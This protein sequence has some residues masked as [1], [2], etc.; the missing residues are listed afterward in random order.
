MRTNFVFIVFIMVV[1]MS[2]F[3]QSDLVQ[4]YDGTLA[5]TT[6]FG[7]SGTIATAFQCWTSNSTYQLGN[8]T[9]RIRDAQ[10]GA[11]SGTISLYLYNGDGTSA[12]TKIITS[13]TTLAGSS[14]P[15]SDTNYNFDFSSSNQTITNG[16]DY[17]FVI[18]TTVLNSGAYFNVDDGSGGVGESGY[19][20]WGATSWTSTYSGTKPYVY[21]YDIDLPSPPIVLQNTS[22]EST[23]VVKQTGSLD[24]S[25]AVFQTVISSNFNV[26][27]NN[28]QIYGAYNFQIEP[29]ATNTI[30]CELL[31]DGSVKG[32]ITRSN[33]AAETGSV[34][35][36][37]NFFVLQAGNHSQELQCKKTLGG[38]KFT[39]SN[40]VGIGHFM[41]DEN[42]NTI[43]NSEKNITSQT[44]TSGSSFTQIGEINLTINNRTHVNYSQQLVVDWTLAYSN[45]HASKEI[46]SSYISIN[47]TNCSFYPRTV[48]SGTVGSV[49]GNCLLKNVTASST[50]NIKLFAN[51]TNAEYNGVMIAKNFFL[52]PN[53][54]NSTTINNINFSGAETSLLN[55]TGGNTVHF[56]TNAFIK[57]GIPVKANQSTTAQFRFSI[58]DGS[59]FNSINVSRDLTTDIGILIFHDIFEDLS[60]DNYTLELFGDCGLASCEIVG[61]EIVGYVTDTTTTTARNSFNL[62]VQ[63]NYNDGSIGGSFMALTSD[64]NTFNSVN[65]W[66]LIF[67]EKA[68]ENVS[69]SAYNNDYFNYTVFNHNTTTDLTVKLNQTII[70]WDCFEKVTNNNMNCTSPA[71]ST[72]FNYNVGGNP[73]TQS[74]NVT[75]Y[76]ERFISFNV[77]ALQNDTFNATSIYSTNLTLTSNS[78]IGSVTSCNYTIT[79]ITY[80]SFTESVIG[81]PNTYTGLINGTYNISSDCVGYAILSQSILIENV[82]Q[83]LN[84][85]LLTTNSVQLYF[86]DA[87]TLLIMNETNIT[88][89]FI[90]TTA[91]TNITSNGS[92]YVDLLS[93]DAYTII[94]DAEGYRQGSYIF[95]L[96]NRTYNPFNLYMQKENKSQLVLITVKD[97][98]GN[99][100]ENSIVTIQKYVNNSWITE[101]IRETDFQ[102]RT[103]AHFIL[104]TEFYNFVVSVDDTTYFGALNNDTK[105]KQIYAEDVSNGIEVVIN[106]IDDTTITTYQSLYGIISSLT[107]VN[108]SNITGYFRF[109]WDDSTNE[110]HTGLLNVYRD[111][112][113]NCTSSTTTESGII[114]CYINETGN[115]LYSAKGSIDDKVIGT[116]NKR[117]TFG[118]DKYINWGIFGFAFMFILL[119]LVIFVFS[120][121][122]TFSLF[123][124]TAVFCLG[125]VFGIIF[126]ETNMTI[127]SSLLALATLIG[128]IRS[129][130]GINS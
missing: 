128:A 64:G 100:I 127:I 102:G 94:F 58:Y 5:R 16:Q 59:T 76:Y 23:A 10:A 53:E 126:D 111:G 123:S 15:T 37:S 32:N 75:G 29:S 74:I 105:K 43:I 35:I 13:T 2:S 57:L 68:L 87:E 116:Y 27:V 12:T 62:T 69:I 20:N 101:Q 66:T 92:L 49:G 40:A 113:L 67:T 80:P 11:N 41:I 45:N 6:S 24:I 63:D 33:I 84:F 79:G 90:G 85:E 7:Y 117:F 112:V 73:Y 47:N 107:Y 106:R 36:M 60:Q 38:G 42:N 65:G 125:I 48:N 19:G 1:M 78:T 108:T 46:I 98:Y 8:M 17:C 124:G 22:V 96:L 130:G 103:E 9:V 26:S 129:T 52:H 61:G 39:I 99:Y 4:Y 95:T 18:N 89:Q 120:D 114:Y 71:E 55:M 14:I 30:F 115:V 86:F 118:N 31:I 3:V 21:L 50:Y 25:S 97:T 91:Q 54:I 110:V 56:N 28:T 119:V 93:P 83:S 77:T 51:G 72:I 121:S 81:S 44:V 122:P 82:T 109:S 88:V 104:S 34:A 70:N